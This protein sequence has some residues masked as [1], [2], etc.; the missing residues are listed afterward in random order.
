MTLI[1][2]AEL[3]RF[4]Q[5]DVPYGDL[6]TRSLGL[7][8]QPAQIHFRAGAAMVAS[9]TEEAARIMA[10]LGCV[11]TP[12]V[13][14][15]AS[16]GAGDLLLSAHGPAEAVLSGWKVAQTLME[17]ASGIGTATARI[18]TAARAVRPDVVVACTRKTF[19]GTK[20]IAIKAIIAAGATPHRLG[21]SDTVLM[22]P[23]H[24]ALL[25]DVS[26]AQ[27]IARLKQSCPEKKIVVEVNSE[28]EAEAAAQAGAHVIQLEK[29]PPERVAALV[30]RLAKVPVLIAAA[31]GVNAQ[32]AAAYAASGARI[33]VTSAPYSAAPMDVK[34]TIMPT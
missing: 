4:L 16:V 32:N 6:T 5:D 30:E 21:L 3:E 11:V 12:G 15:G 34:V 22:F 25:G 7:S 18:V 14:S 29:F 26:M 28:S 27:A 1:S 31:G 8:T 23:E 2:D 19:P 17:Y 10:R 20:A 24:R 33:L 9:S 13:S